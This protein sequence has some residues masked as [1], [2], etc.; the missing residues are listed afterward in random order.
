MF[1]LG[2]L[3]AALLWLPS[4]NVK[5]LSTQQARLIVGDWS[6]ERLMLDDKPL[7]D[8]LSMSM[9]FLADGTVKIKGS[10]GAVTEG[11]YALTEGKLYF[12]D[13]PVTQLREVTTVLK[14][15]DAVLELE[16]PYESRVATLRM[17]RNASAFE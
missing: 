1:L 16:V 11:K 2:A 5:N 4:C 17:V 13:G 8:D 15:S 3:C 7:D 12:Q 6:L 10:N 14:L 9:R